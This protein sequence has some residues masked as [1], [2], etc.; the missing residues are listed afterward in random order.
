MIIIPAYHQKYKEWKLAK[1]NDTIY[2]S[3]DKTEWGNL[4]IHKNSFSF[5]SR[6]QHFR[7]ET[8]NHGNLIF[9]MLLVNKLT[10]SIIQRYCFE[11]IV[12]YVPG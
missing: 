1:M 7:F 6:R 11:L 8:K 12:S 4:N 9:P 3:L 10:G 2:N 5:S